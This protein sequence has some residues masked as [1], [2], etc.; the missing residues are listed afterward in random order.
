MGIRSQRRKLDNID[1]FE[2]HG[3]SVRWITSGDSPQHHAFLRNLLNTLKSDKRW[4]VEEFNNKI[5]AYSI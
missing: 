1:V 5:V 4:K 3:K 2:M